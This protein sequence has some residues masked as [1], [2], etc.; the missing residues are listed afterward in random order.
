MRHTRRS[1][2]SRS[3]VETYIVP[4]GT[5]FLFD[6]AHDEGFALDHLGALVWDYCD[7][8]TAHDD[9]IA[10]ITALL[11]GDSALATR[12]S[13]LLASF[14]AQGLLEPDAESEP[15]AAQARHPHVG[16]T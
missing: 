9:I 8:Q 4:D 6:P 16:A 11:P 14:A 15:S 13:D 5:C 12:V 3:D 10:E 1:P 2:K 7:G